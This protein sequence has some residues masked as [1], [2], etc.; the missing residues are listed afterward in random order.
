MRMIKEVLRL[1]YSCGLSHKKISKAIGCSHGAVA[2]YIHRAQAAGY[3]WPLPEEIDDA[4]LEKRLFPPSIKHKGKPQPDCNYIQ[5]ELKKKG[6]TLVQLWSE[7]RED[8]PDGYGLTQFCDIYGAYRKNLNLVMRQEHKAG[9]KA[10]S[11]FAGK[12]IPIVIDPVT[13]ETKLAH[14]FVCTLGASNFTFADLYWGEDVEAWC[15]GH[16]DAFKYFDGCPK[17]VVPDNPK[18]VVTK[19]CRYE[20]DI[21]PTFAQMAAHYD[22]V[23]IPARVRKPKDKA[24]VEAAVGLATRWILAVLR[25][26]IFFSLGEARVAV[27]ELLDKLNERPFK[28]ISGSRRSLYELIDRPALKALPVV[29]FE[30]AEFKDASVHIDY[31]IEFDDHFYSVPHQFRGEV[32]EVR[33]TYS[34]IEVFRR[35][36]RIASHPRG[37]P[38]RKASTL[39][40]HRPKN[41]QQYG[42]WPPEQIVNWAKRIGPSTASLVET[43]LA[44]RQHPEQGYRSCLGILRLAKKFSDA[45]L[46]TA[47]HRALAIRGISYKSVKSIL[48]SN[49][50]LRPLAEKPQQLAIVHANIRGASAF[51]ITTGEENDADTSNNRHNENPETLRNGTSPGSATGTEGGA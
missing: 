39:N 11:D 18:A 7:Y 5:S 37:L 46:E 6:V 13:G 16:A 10:F 50:D 25:N 29:P 15:D 42:D 44:R 40:E 3:T 26:R 1:H 20:P 43:I 22:L 12:T 34:T 36:K 27:R 8:Y 38:D 2:E 32:V 14:L 33:A 21:N 4:Q 19:P 28:K 41:H 45:R 31:H 51:A 47:C 17:I 48:D 49:L 9:E 35:G 30:Y 24:K 23:V